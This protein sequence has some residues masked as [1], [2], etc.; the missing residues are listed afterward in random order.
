MWSDLMNRAQMKEM[1]EME[2]DKSELG[3]GEEREGATEVVNWEN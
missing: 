3:T 1:V 2:K